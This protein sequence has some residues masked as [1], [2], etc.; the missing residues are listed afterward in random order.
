MPW[1]VAGDADEC[2]PAAARTPPAL[3]L[4]TRSARVFCID[5]TCDSRCLIRLRHVSIRV[6][7]RAARTRRLTRR[8]RPPNYSCLL[9]VSPSRTPVLSPYT[10]C[11]VDPLLRHIASSSS[12]SGSERLGVSLSRGVRCE[13]IRDLRKL[14]RREK[15]RSDISRCR[16]LRVSNAGKTYVMKLILTIDPV[17]PTS[18]LALTGVSHSDPRRISRVAIFGIAYRF[19]SASSVLRGGFSLDGAVRRLS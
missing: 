15:T 7:K 2:G 17:D 12:G 13:M 1:R 9:W 18:A 10:A 6:G 8:R 4:E 19:F 11:K 16:Q 14:L 3:M 5:V